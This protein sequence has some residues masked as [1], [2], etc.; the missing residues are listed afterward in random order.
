MDADPLPESPAALDG[1]AAVEDLAAFGPFF[2]ARAHPAGA[3][4]GP[5][6]RSLA[7]LG[8][9]PEALG[10]RV[11]AVRAGLAAAQG[12]GP[13]PAASVEFTVAASVAHLGLAARL[14]SPALA[15]A[16]A[17]RRRLAASL[18]GLWWQPVL[19]GPV[20]LSVALDA[21]HGAPAGAARPAELLHACVAD[22][23]VGEL[24]AA[25]GSLRVSPRVLWGNVASAVHGAAALVAAARPGLAEQVR[26]ATAALMARPPLRGAGGA[27]DDGRFLRRSC[28]LIY[29]AA[30]DRRGPLC[31]DCVLL[32][33]RSSRRLR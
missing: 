16:V 11:A 25:F 17:H 27:A 12:G 28:C 1:R 31:G 32:P 22:G 9:E 15:L 3:A 20:P 2:A 24:T 4:P 6:W 19:G 29:R 7:E 14:V 33:V 30:P 18:D 21:V 26:A 13:D 23:P 5:P 10:A 8:R